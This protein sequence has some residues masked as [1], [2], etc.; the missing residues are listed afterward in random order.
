MIS[1][2]LML[3]VFAVLLWL[4]WYLLPD[5]RRWTWVDSL[6]VFVLFSLAVAFNHF[7]LNAHYDD[8][9]PLWPQLVS[10]VGMYAIFASGLAI[11][12]AWRRR[13][14]ENRS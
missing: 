1:A 4:Y 8:A 2:A 10:A 11:G 5:G 3:P 7:A 14:S 6:L 12:L 13:S 9:G